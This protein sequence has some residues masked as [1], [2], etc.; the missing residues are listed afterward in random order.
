MD[1]EQ[2]EGY[3]PLTIALRENDAAIAKLLIEAGADINCPRAFTEAVSQENLNMCKLLIEH[4]YDVNMPLSDKCHSAVHLAAVFN[5]DIVRYLVEKCAADIF[6]ELGRLLENA[7]ITDRPEV[8]DYLLQ[9]AYKLRGDEVW[10]GYT[11]PGPLYE[12]LY[13][14]SVFCTYVLLRWGFN[15]DVFNML[16]LDLG[17]I[18]SHF[19]AVFRNQHVSINVYIT[20]ITLLKQMYP[21]SL[22][23]ERFLWYIENINTN[24]LMKKFLTEL[25]RERKN[26]SRLNNMCRTHIFQQLGYNPIPKADKL[27]LPRNLINFVQFRD[28]EDLYVV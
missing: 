19:L 10:W 22:Q 13:H 26:P 5:V 21:H 23:D 27:P 9:H 2:H 14:Q 18:L 8:L 25:Y 24:N 20:A 28:V 16:V 3:R 17:Y 1:I 4:G 11:Y 6:T 7:V 12:A 15:N